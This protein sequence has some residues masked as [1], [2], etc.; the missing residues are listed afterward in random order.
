ME[1]YID[2]FERVVDLLRVAGGYVSAILSAEVHTVT[3]DVDVDLAVDDY[4][5]FNGVAKARIVEVVDARVF[6]VKAFGGTIAGMG[7]WKAMAPYFT[8]GSRKVIDAMLLQKNGYE[9]VYQKYPLIALRLP[10]PIDDEGGV[11]TVDANI[12]I[13]TFTKKTSKPAERLATTFKPVLYP[14]YK[15]FLEMCKRSGEFINFNPDH[16]HI[17]RMYYGTGGEDE[18]IDSVFSDPL[19]AVELRNLR[20]NYILEN[21][22]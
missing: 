17:D 2:K 22:E 14:L 16:T 8:Y 5:L 6:K 20:L 18:N 9:F 10:A 12:L 11:S 21:C 4:L 13:A 19:D 7:T 1:N 15:Q 3:S